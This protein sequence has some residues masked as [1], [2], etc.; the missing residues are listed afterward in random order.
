MRKAAAWNLT[1]VDRSTRALAEEAARRAGMSLDDWIEE[2]VAEQAS[3]QGVG[4]EDADDDDSFAA[5]PERGRPPAARERAARPERPRPARTY[6][7]KSARFEDSVEDDETDSRLQAALARFEARAART[8]KQTAKALD[9]VAKLVDRDETG[10]ERERARLEKALARDRADLAAARDEAARATSSEQRTVKA[11][12]TVAKWIDRDE[13][14][15]DTERA[16]LEKA[17]EKE[18]AEAAA[19]REEAARAARNEQRTVQALETVAE[20]ID[21]DAAP[22]KPARQAEPDDELDRRLDALAKRVVQG[23]RRPVEP[24]RQQLRREPVVDEEEPLGVETLRSE[25][26]GLNARLDKI[27][28]AAPEPAPRAA[29][30]APP[31]RPKPIDRSLTRGEADALRAEIA[32]MKRSLADLAPRNA[33]IAL[34][35]AMKD[36]GRRLDVSRRSA[37]NSETLQPIEDMLR[38]V[39]EAL[40]R[41]NPQP[42][43][44]SVERDLRALN[45]KINSLAGATVDPALLDQ[46]RRQTE[47]IRRQLAAAALQTAPLTRV[48]REIEQIADRLDRFAKTPIPQ[49]E[50]D[51]LVRTLAETRAQIERATPPAALASIEERLASLTTRI[52]EALRL[53]SPPPAPAAS[54]ESLND[55][56]KLLLSRLEDL[57]AKAASP[58]A[59]D[60]APF[61]DL[62]R[63]IEAVRSS[64]DQRGDLDAQTHR[65]ES[66]LGDLRDRLDVSI[67]AQPDAGSLNATLQLLLRRVE[68][69]AARPGSSGAFDPAPMHE[70]ARR[71]DALRDSLEQRGDVGFYAHRLENALGDLRD[72][73]DQSVGA[74]NESL[75]STLQHLLG[76]VD[77]LASRPVGYDAAPF[78][79]LARRIEAVRAQMESHGEI[80]APAERLEAQLAEVSAKLDSSLTTGSSN[81]TVN[82]NLQKVMARLEE[83]AHH[84]IQGGGAVIDLAA[85]RDLASRVD[86]LRGAMERQIDLRPKLTALAD[87]LEEI[88]A[89]LETAQIGTPEAKSLISVIQDLAQRVDRQPAAATDLKALETM[90]QDIAHR[91]VAVDNSAIQAMLS[92]LGR[93]IETGARFDTGALMQWM[94]RLDERLSATDTRPMEQAL[95][96]LEDRFAA[97]EAIGLDPRQIEEAADLIARRLGPRTGYNPDAEALFAQIGDIQNRL[98]SLSGVTESNAA[99]ERTVAELIAEF[100]TTRRFLQATP[101]AAAPNGALAEDLAELKN[102]QAN[103]D[104]RMAARMSR[105]QEILEQLTDRLRQLEDDREPVASESNAVAVAPA[106]NNA[107]SR[108]DFAG[109]PDR[110]A[111]SAPPLPAAAARPKTT[112]TITPAGGAEEDDF[113][114]EPGSAAPKTTRKPEDAQEDEAAKA[115]D[116]QAHIAAARRAAMAE[117]NSKRDRSAASIM[118]EATLKKVTPP[119]GPIPSRVK[120]QGQ[121]MSPP[122]KV[123]AV[124]G[125][126]MPFLILAALVVAAAAGATY[127]LRGGHAPLAQKSELTPNIPATPPVAQL[128]APGVDYS[129]TGSVGASRGPIVIPALDAAPKPA[130][131]V[132]PAPV[133]S[134]L[135]ADLVATLLDG[136]PDALRDAAL[137]G[138]AGAETEVGLRYLE[139]R[140]LPRDPKIASRW[141][142]LA[143]NQGLPFAQYRVAALYEKGIGVVKDLALARGWYQK[144]ADAGNARAMHN[145]AVLEAEDAGAGK[146]DYALAAQGFR[147]AAELGV[148]DSQFNLGVLYGRGLGVS[149]DL[150]QSWVWFSLAAQ[151]GD[152]D[153]AKKRD[154]VAVKMDAKTLAAASK[155]L[156]DTKLRKPVAAANEAP[157]PAGGW[158]ARSGASQAAKPAPTPTTPAAKT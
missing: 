83:I 136:Q 60:S 155:A 20:L 98:E 156:G 73:L 47:D 38:Q 122:P 109:I 12:E 86:A 66:A 140:T 44:S 111:A 50:I 92:D 93:K 120:P 151:Q 70:I 119:L 84:P 104:R 31:H 110:P 37:P 69:L 22:R 121:P 1:S 17:L 90:I 100:E 158:D 80:G 14:E 58:R 128:D 152:T 148:R 75:S 143:A 139:G 67:G 107:V 23:V 113:L 36:L 30:V 41:H 153:A 114:L 19:A 56:M 53:A 62:A 115:S 40:R 101:L 61:Q 134:K 149:Q 29:Q 46:I 117:M 4:P 138:D 68:D 52:D 72:R 34:E 10:R 125:R 78:Q 112:V 127:E 48:E 94:N 132:A 124:S 45:Q 57:A 105:V 91:P 144:A 7:Q 51:R 97:R 63:R 135:P 99:L 28:T 108:I 96:S 142:E 150:A 55:A 3:D 5:S 43:A 131:T 129:A 130:P 18:R 77:D 71:V 32:A 116:L 27:R 76:R 49:H 65:L 59:H 54:G 133:A 21:S 157:T 87:N 74:T 82:A 33:N 103:A 13:G 35:G 85:H 147:G 26:A 146:P 81:E 39:L 118:A 42:Q 145:L 79:D 16:R 89:R 25:I 141:L 95:R 88:R 9:S 126:R 102:E 154:E 137:A 64:L 15:R 2:M 11:L 24:A 106:A 123:A 8:E 6:G